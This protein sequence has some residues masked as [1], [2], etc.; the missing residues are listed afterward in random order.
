MQKKFNNIR[1]QVS[2]SVDMCEKV[3][4]LAYNLGV[5]RSSLCSV[6]IGQ[7]IMSFEKGF[8]I[9]Q[10]TFNEDFIE[11]LLNDEVSEKEKIETSEEENKND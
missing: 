6:L 7:G 4:K 3:D 10:N 9:V 2:L 8:E 1:V 5:S 11:K